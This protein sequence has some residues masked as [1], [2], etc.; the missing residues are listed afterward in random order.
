MLLARPLP[1]KGI[2]S[3]RYPWLLLVVA[4]LVIVISGRVS[5]GESISIYPKYNHKAQF[6]GIYMAKQKGFFSNQGLQAN[7][8]D[9]DPN[10]DSIEA[11]KKGLADYSIQDPGI[12]TEIE[13]GV[14]FVVVAAYG[15]KPLWSLTF[16]PEF[17]SINDLDGY[18][19][20]VASGHQKK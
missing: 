10:T 17:D 8:L 14:D 19:I 12:L 18:P 13:M 16:K 5:A 6:A 4:F 3:K 2:L 7:I 9:Y 11:V 20:A 1:Y 15:Q